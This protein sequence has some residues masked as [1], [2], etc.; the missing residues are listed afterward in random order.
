MVSRTAIIEPRRDFA[1]IET[2]LESIYAQLAPDA[3]VAV[4]A[5]RLV[6]HSFGKLR[7]TAEKK[8]P[9]F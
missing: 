1:I 5:T 2:E 3:D 6:G 7:E 8:C 4:A 9:T